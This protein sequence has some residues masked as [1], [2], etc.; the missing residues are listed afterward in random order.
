MSEMVLDS[1]NV[2]IVLISISLFVWKCS[3]MFIMRYM[4]VRADARRQYVEDVDEAQIE[5]EMAKRHQEEMAFDKRREDEKRTALE[6]IQNEMRIAAAADARSFT[7]PSGFEDFDVAA[8]KITNRG[9][10]FS[11][12]LDN[13]FDASSRR[14]RNDDRRSNL[15][16]NDDRASFVPGRLGD[17]DVAMTR[18]YDHNSETASASSGASGASGRRVARKKGDPD[19]VAMTSYVPAA[20]AKAENDGFGAG[21]G[22]TIDDTIS[23]FFAGSN[24]Y[25]DG[26]YHEH[27]K[28]NKDK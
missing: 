15:S 28:T 7:A 13:F 10:Q 23:S 21:A 6:K 3:R 4:E 11:N 9:D 27:Y 5:I 1:L 19:A 8:A 24:A 16:K 22:G 14:D 20:L 26:S 25:N 2:L 12:M 18:K 17:D